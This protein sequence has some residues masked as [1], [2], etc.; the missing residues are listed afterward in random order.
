MMCTRPRKF[1][2]FKRDLC[3]GVVLALLALGLT[4]CS[5]HRYQSQQRAACHVAD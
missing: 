2:T 1:S 3:A 5:E 4:E